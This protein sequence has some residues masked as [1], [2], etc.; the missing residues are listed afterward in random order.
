MDVRSGKTPL[1]GADAYSTVR[2][3]MVR[4]TTIRVE[5]CFNMGDRMYFGPENDGLEFEEFNRFYKQRLSHYVKSETK[6]IYLV[7]CLIGSNCL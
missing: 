4:S 1:L 5:M 7:C 2:V 6:R 3:L